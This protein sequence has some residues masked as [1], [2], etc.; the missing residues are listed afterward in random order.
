M[1]TEDDLR[2]NEAYEDLLEDVREE[3]S[4]HGNVLSCNIPRGKFG[5]DD[6]DNGVGFIFVEY[7]SA[8]EATRALVAIG[9]KKFNGNPVKATYY[10]ERAYH[11]AVSVLGDCVC[12]NV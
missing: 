7:A 2:D 8:P 4:K 11:E 12:A 9:G 6:S 5:G 3:F 10:S 1:T